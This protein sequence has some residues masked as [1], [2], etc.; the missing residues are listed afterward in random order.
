MTITEAVELYHLSRVGRVAPRTQQWDEQRL[1]PL[2]DFFGPDRA[3]EAIT[4]EELWRWRAWLVRR[5]T[6]YGDHP[7]KPEVEG[8]LS[9]YTLR[10]H[11]QAVRQFFRWAAMRGY[12]PRNPAEGLEMPAKPDVEPKAV[13]KEDL[14]GLMQAARES[15]PRDY[16]IV[17]FL[18]DTGCRAGGLV[19]LTLSNLDLGSQTATVKEKGRG[20]G[21]QRRVHL[22]EATV[23][24]LRAWLE[25]RP[26][27]RSD[28]VF[29]GSKGA[30]TPSGLYQILERLAQRA[31]IAGRFNP[32]SFRHG[33]A[34][35]LLEN[36]ADLGTVSQLLGHSS[37]EV[38]HD[39][40]ARWTPSELAER[41]RRFH[42]LNGAREDGEG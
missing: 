33:F 2:A 25:E 32:H 37:I 20:G 35:G 8:G 42:W 14:L 10:G 27:T 38:T 19:S 4:L 22:T 1:R 31:G 24:A 36:G 28:R 40:Y 13:G 26:T 9:N 39:F 16:A 15:G 17:L 5:G 7:T 21:K 6:R 12:I 30:L 3:I 34:R 23:D 41:H 18:A 29:L 11:I